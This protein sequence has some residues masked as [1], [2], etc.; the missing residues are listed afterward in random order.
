M[1]KSIM[2]LLSKKEYN[3]EDLRDIMSILR[4]PDGCPWDTEQTHQSIRNNLIEEAYE[5][6]EAIDLADDALLKEELGD[7]L[8][9]VV[10]HSEIANQDKRFNMNDVCDGICKKLI[11]RHPHIFGEIKANTSEQVLINWDE[12]KKTEKGHNSHTDSI[13]SIAKS[14]PSLMRS[15]KIQKKA[16]KAGFDWPNVNGAL[17]KVEEELGELKEAISN[18]DKAHIKEELGDLLFAVVNIARF[19]DCDSENALFDACDK[20][21]NRFSLVEQEALLNGKKLEEMTL[22]EMDVLWE[23]AKVF[24]PK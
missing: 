6:V 20:F 9:Q 14:L 18:E 23:R 16:A 1:K 13:K 8:L 15:Q 2:E 12:I 21:T 3:F 17:E 10:F 4:S 22:E 11:L 24:N 5:V 7:L 19:V